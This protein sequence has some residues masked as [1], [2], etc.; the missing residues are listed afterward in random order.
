MVLLF[1]VIFDTIKQNIC[2]VLEITNI[3]FYSYS[4]NIDG[5]FYT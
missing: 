2:E 3:G 1:L 5:K 4:Y